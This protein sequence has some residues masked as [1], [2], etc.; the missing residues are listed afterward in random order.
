MGLVIPL[1]QAPLQIGGE[2]DAA[3]RKHAEATQW[4]SA[5]NN[6]GTTWKERRRVKKLEVYDT[7]HAMVGQ[8]RHKP[9]ST[10]SSHNQ[11]WLLW[12]RS[13]QKP[14]AIVMQPG[15]QANRTSVS[16]MS[17]MKTQILAKHIMKKE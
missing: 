17:E 5:N 16:R 7:S 1:R 6:Q 15:A 13:D 11:N 9:V 4:T 8:V 3:S 14:F 10:K 12:A 2:N